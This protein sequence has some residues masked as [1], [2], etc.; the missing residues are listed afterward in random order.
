MVFGTGTHILSSPEALVVQALP[1]DNRLG[2]RVCLMAVPPS[3]CFR[4]P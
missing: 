4:D 1:T 3:L 2:Y